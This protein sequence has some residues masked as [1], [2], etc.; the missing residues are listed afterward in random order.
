M[1]RGVRNYP[2]DKFFVLFV[3]F[4]F[5]WCVCACV[6][7]VGWGGGCSRGIMK[8]MVE[9][10]GIG[11][12]GHYRIFGYCRLFLSHPTLLSLFHLPDGFDCR[13]T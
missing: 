8:T 5:F 13:L 9:L 10:V 11:L 12:D 6:L 4:F 1:I 7:G 2:F 3:S